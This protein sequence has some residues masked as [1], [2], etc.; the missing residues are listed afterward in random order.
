MEASLK[1]DWGPL[2]HRSRR[3]EHSISSLSVLFSRYRTTVT[4]SIGYRDRYDLRNY[5]SIL[6]VKIHAAMIICK[7]HT[8]TCKGLRKGLP[9]SPGTQ[10]VV[11]ACLVASAGLAL[12]A[13]VKIEVRLNGHVKGGM[14]L[15]IEKHLN[16]GESAL[17]PKAFGDYLQRQTAIASHLATNLSHIQYNSHYIAYSESGKKIASDDRLIYKRNWLW[18][19]QNKIRRRNIESN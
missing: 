10:H 17:Q 4:R 16:T 11:L 12:A 3:T 7:H 9:C 5:N 13:G 15:D 1:W 14:P 8:S 18:T 19:N 6:I 2:I